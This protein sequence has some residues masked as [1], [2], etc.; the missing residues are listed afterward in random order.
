MPWDGGRIHGAPV[1]VESSGE[2]VELRLGEPTHV[3]ATPD[4]VATT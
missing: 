4:A 1:E 2:H 3:A